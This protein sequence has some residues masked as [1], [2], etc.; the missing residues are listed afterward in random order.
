MGN[1]TCCAG[2]SEGT[3]I[4]EVV[5]SNR[6]LKKAMAGLNAD[7]EAGLTIRGVGLKEAIL[8]QAALRGYLSRRMVGS[9]R[10]FKPTRDDIKDLSLE[11][12][13]EFVRHA[14][15]VLSQVGDIDK[16]SLNEGTEFGPVLFTDDSIYVGAWSHSN[17]RSGFGIQ[18]WPS[19]RFYK[20]FWEDDKPSGEGVE[21]YEDG[22][23]Y[24]GQFQ[25]GVKEGEGTLMTQD[26]GRYSG[27]WKKGKKQGN[28]M[29]I[30]A[31]KST[32]SG[33]YNNN[34]IEGHGVFTWANKTHVY[35]GEW[36]AGEK[37]GHGLMK[38]EDGKSYE[39]NWSHNKQHGE[40]VLTDGSLQKK[41]EWNAG[42]RT[43][44]LS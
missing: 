3:N 22:S 20:G 13:A 37:H 35:E 33:E 30:F 31:D 7:L 9:A 41:G 34:A 43:K 21:F 5:A 10:P 38:W 19:H 32:Y 17:Q 11:V 26:G 36:K 4:G 23:A 40:G 12:P 44:W 24:K 16:Q 29:E 39:G 14:N 28:G 6:P 42:R 18:Y 8:L 27:S 2:E 25:D 1:T 15:D